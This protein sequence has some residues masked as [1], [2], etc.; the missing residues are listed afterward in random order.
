MLYDDKFIS[1]LPETEE[2]WKSPIVVHIAKEKN[3]QCKQLK[4]FI[5]QWFER[6][7]GE[8]KKS[9]STRLKSLDDEV[10]LAQLSELFVYDFCDKL[11]EINRDPELD[12]GK[13]PELIWNIQDNRALLDVVTL[14]DNDERGKSNDAIDYLLNY[15]GKLEHYYN[16][17][18]E[19]ENID[20]PTL[21]PKKIKRKLIKY[22]DC[23]DFQNIKDGEELKIDEF[24]FAGV[25]FPVCKPSYQKEKVRF[26][27]LMGP[28]QEIQPNASISNRIRSKL[29]KYKWDGPLFVAIC[30]SA[31]FGVDWEDVAEVLYGPSL[32]RYNPKMEKHKTVLGEGG[33]L[34][35]KEK[36]APKNTS[37][38]GVL[39]CE[40]AWRGGEMPEFK[41]GYF[42]NPFA[43]Y[44]ITLPVCT[45]PTIEKDKV[46]FDWKHNER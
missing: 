5:E 35:P 3:E 30:K 10:F 9:Y 39:F 25:F 22:L 6:I 44:P 43:K 19:Y 8:Q 18:I 46:V 17:S 45:Y 1:S 41:V 29:K 20:R 12:N 24:G 23:L 32:I 21:E 16:L 13:T 15:L 33:I 34:M 28:S 42:I 2:A 27:S 7:E 37:L 36:S 11:G 31:S 40:L 4:I 14:F 26:L 38:T